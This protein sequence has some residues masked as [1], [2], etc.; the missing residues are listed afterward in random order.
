MR[1]L[2]TI[3]TILSL[4]VLALPASASVPKRIFVEHFGATW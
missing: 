2:S 4:L 1:N 3:V